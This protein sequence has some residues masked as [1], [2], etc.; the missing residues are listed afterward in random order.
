MEQEINF[1][2][3]IVEDSTSLK[4]AFEISAKTSIYRK[5][6][7]APLKLLI[8][9]G[10]LPA[11][12]SALNF[13]KGRCDKDSETIRNELGNCSDY[14]YTYAPYPELLGQHFNFVYAG[15]VL[16][17]LLPFAREVVWKQLSRVTDKNSGVCFVAVRSNTDKGIKGTPL[18]DCVVTS[19]GTVQIGYSEEKLIEEAQSHFE[20]CE[21]VKTSGYRVVRCSHSRNN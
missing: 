18:E 8:K 3:E 2:E 10:Y 5:T 14:D 1:V 15:Y 16:N 13:G 17:T 4:L 9:L 7:S 19:K 6:A 20:F 12:G 21:I 11:N